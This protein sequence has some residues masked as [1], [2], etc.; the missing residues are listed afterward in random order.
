M[1]K[2]TNNNKNILNKTSLSDFIIENN[3][4]LQKVRCAIYTRKSCEDGLELEYNSLENQYDACA[5]FVKSHEADGWFVINKRY[6]DGGFSGGSLDRPALKVKFYKAFTFVAG[7][8]MVQGFPKLSSIV[9]FIVKTGVPPLPPRLQLPFI[10]YSEFMLIFSA[11]ASIFFA[12]AFMVFAS[13]VI[14]PFDTISISPLF[15]K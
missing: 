4:P 2:F 8:V 10:L 7:F 14:L 9:V 1:N 12:V 15:F 11:V 13:I 5:G 3:S 6:D